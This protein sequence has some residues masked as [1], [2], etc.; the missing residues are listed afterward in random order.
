ML[1]FEY[2]CC[3]LSVD[4]GL[5]IDVVGSAEMLWFECGCLEVLKEMM[6]LR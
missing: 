6:Y 1:W 2:R 4:A 3:G 5:S